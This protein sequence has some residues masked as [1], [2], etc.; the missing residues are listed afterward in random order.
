M[1]LLSIIS[2]SKTEKAKGSSSGRDKMMKGKNKPHTKAAKSK[3]RIYGSIKDALCNGYIG[4]IFS[5]K[6][7]DRLYVIT[8]RKWGDDDEQECGGRV[9]KGFTPGSIPSSFRDVKKYAARTMVRH[10]KSASSNLKKYFK[11]NKEGKDF[12]GD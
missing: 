5:T 7:S 1:D 6:N 11:K 8:K 12:K 3:V 2:E 4:Q 10:G 9:A